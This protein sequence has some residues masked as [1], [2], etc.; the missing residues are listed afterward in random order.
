MA[1]D[2]SCWQV[3]NYLRRLRDSL[4]AAKTSPKERK[5]NITP[6]EIH[7]SMDLKGKTTHAVGTRFATENLE[8]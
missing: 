6:E 1:L 8:T 3:F 5:K 4:A 2:S 7:S